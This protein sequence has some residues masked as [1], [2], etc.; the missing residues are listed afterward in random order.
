MFSF[1]F[2]FVLSSNLVLAASLTFQQPLFMCTVSAAI[3][4]RSGALRLLNAPPSCR[5]GPE[6]LTANYICLLRPNLIRCSLCVR[7]A[8]K[9][10]R[11]RFIQKLALK[12]GRNKVEVAASVCVI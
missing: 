7:P 6:P 5:K 4:K 3:H 12:R 9:A 8:A 11:A 2:K 10:T 1:V